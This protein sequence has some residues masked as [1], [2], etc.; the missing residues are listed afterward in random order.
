M[1]FSTILS[2]YKK[3]PIPLR[4][5]LWFLICT[6]LQKGISVLTTPIF[7]RILTTEEYGNYN[8][9]NSWLGIVNIFVSLELYAGV[10][11]QGLVK[12]DKEREVFSSSL[13]GLSLTL[14]LIWTIIYLLLRPIWNSL[15]KLTTV[16]MLAMLVM[17]WST[18]AFNF[19]AGEQRVKYRYKT[20][21]FFTLFFSLLKPI[22]EYFCVVLSEDKFTARILG[23]AVVELVGYIGFFVLQLYRGKIFY[24]G[25][26]W[27]YSILFN[28][29][30]VP[31]YLSQTVLNSADR[32]M[33]KSMVSESTAGIYSLAYAL[34]MI[35]T[36]FNTALSHTLSPWIYQKIKDNKALEI[37]PVGYTS[38][39]VIA[40]VNIILIAIA[41]EAISFFAPAEY[42]DAIWVIP[43]IAMSS[44]FLFCYDLFARFEFYYEK[45]RFIMVASVF[46]A[47]LNVILN[48]IFIR[49]FGYYAAGYTTLFCYIVY[50]VGHYMFMRRVCRVYMNN[51]SVYNVG[52]IVGMA[53][54]F[55]SVGFLL[56]LTYN[57]PILR[58][59]IIAI[60]TF[61][62]I[63]KR[64][65][66]L[67]FWR[68]IRKH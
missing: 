51:I 58:F 62:I 18:S 66:F 28:I 35:M 49:K 60:L 4:A 13:Q 26:Y 5:S 34:A 48:Y 3:M 39:G 55:M 16:Q 15:L 68:T 54:A 67:T 36:L 53:V 38:L 63:F 43:P 2:K 8:V 40:I 33:I 21:V 64:N 24:S 22:V 31:H 46:G 37:A 44:F 50:A 19:W 29:P 57:F 20:L 9:F 42:H 1:G 27:K 10:Y 23:L 59:I 45:T 7:T 61:I 6:F 25:K 52:I 47:M 65:F 32:I 30:L 14:S 11:T 56:T 41:P 17:I 12:F